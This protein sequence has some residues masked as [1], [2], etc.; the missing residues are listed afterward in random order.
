MIINLKKKK[1]LQMSEV[2]EVANLFNAWK[3]EISETA[4]AN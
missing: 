4:K 2:D 1:D 3:K